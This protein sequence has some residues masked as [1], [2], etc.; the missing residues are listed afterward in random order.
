MD[1]MSRGVNT[2]VW[3]FETVD[4]SRIAEASR[5]GLRNLVYGASS[6][7][8]HESLLELAVNGVITDLPNYLKQT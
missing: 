2:L 8:E 4:T 1:S 3:Y 6:P 7:A 5:L